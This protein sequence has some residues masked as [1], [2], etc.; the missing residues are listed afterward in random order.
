MFYNS[1]QWYDAIYSWKD[2]A[3]EAQ[4]L[5]AIIAANKATSGQAF[6]DVACGTGGHIAYL[7]DVFDVEG[8]DLDPGMLDIARSKFPA[9]PFHLGNI[10][11]FDLGRQFDVVASLFSSIG[12]A[13]TPERMAQAVRTMAH[14]VRPG[15]VL[16]IEP[17]FAPNDWKPKSSPPKPFVA[18]T[19]AATIVRMV[20]WTR[21]GDVIR[22]TFHYL[23]GDRD[24]V[25]HIT[26]QHDMGL[27]TDGDIRGAF[28]DAGLS[29]TFD[30]D[31]LMGR[32][33]YVGTKLEA[34]DG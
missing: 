33:L 28:V 16:I 17:Y 19:D 6:L 21:D 25:E 10:V 27:F 26:E 29:V 24:H 1:E 2:Y 9:T 18:T 13:V 7:Q 11:D 3:A 30:A 31:G 15:G 32:G 20:D 4:K 23:V 5:H 12:Y 8:L 34:L 14:H 22:S